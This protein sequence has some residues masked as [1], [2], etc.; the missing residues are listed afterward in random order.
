MAERTRLD[1]QIVPVILAGGAGTHLWPL[2]RPDRQGQFLPLIGNRSPFQA[3][4]LRV[5]G[6]AEF[7][8]PLVVCNA[9]HR[10][11]AAE[12]LH[13]IGVTPRAIIVEANGSRMAAAL[14]A[15]ALAGRGDAYMLV[16][17]ADHV[18][19]NTSAFYEAVIRGVAAARLGYFVHFGMPP[20]RPET[21]YR[22]VRRGDALELAGCF[23]VDGFVE[24][25][26][27]ATAT[28][29]VADGRYYWDSG[30][31][32]ASVGPFRDE[33]RQHRPDIAQ[34]CAAS[35]AAPRRDGLFV[36][37]K[38]DPNPAIVG[39]ASDYAV[40]RQSKHAAV[41][42]AD[43]GW[44]C[45]GSW[46]GLAAVMA[47]ET[48]GNATAGLVRALDVTG[49]YLRA[50][51]RLVV[52]VGIENLVVIETPDAVLIAAK[53]R[54]NDVKQL[55]ATLKSEDRSEVNTHARTERPW[56]WFRTLARGP[57]FQVKEIVVGPGAKLSL[58]RHRHR[59]EQWI[60]ASGEALVR[61]GEHELRLRARGYVDIAQ[62][63]IH[64]LTNPSDQPLHVI[65][66]QTGAYLGED[67]IERLADE[68]GRGG[69]HGNADAVV[70]AVELHNP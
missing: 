63:Q 2:S 38:A 21:G 62:G 67:D 59:A 4:V 30:L 10:S 46:S 6:R 58:Q 40:I 13:K 39:E 1:A 18:I 51:S 19:A 3:T 60:V 16:L 54:V 8:S 27:R 29:Y 65:E 70:G 14:A 11:V 61:L 28:S 64:R 37:P 22:Y 55:V 5:S 33:V 57:G 15:F 69:D 24:D 68:Y 35:L 36:W 47:E 20:D 31:L 48:D 41:L 26:D 52:A 34:A 43:M 53:D 45:V 50:E 56:G 42:P 25:P 32:L 17:P 9:E 7:G 12:Q 49:S 23:A 66:V 44:S